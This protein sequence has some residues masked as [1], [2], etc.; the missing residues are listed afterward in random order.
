MFTWLKYE[1]DGGDAVVR[2]SLFVAYACQNTY[3]STLTG[4]I[5]HCNERKF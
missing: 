2:F 1:E 4:V 3:M 5:R